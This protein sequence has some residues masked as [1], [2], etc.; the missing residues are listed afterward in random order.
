[1]QESKDS[2]IQ[3]VTMCRKIMKSNINNERKEKNFYQ[4]D[5]K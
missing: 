2:K 1:M 4:E 5:S 3:G